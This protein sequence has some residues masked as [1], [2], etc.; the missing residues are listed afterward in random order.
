MLVC[1]GMP[2][3]VPDGVGGCLVCNGVNTYQDV[4]GALSCK[5]V[6]S[7]LSSQFVVLQPT[8]TSDRVCRNLTQCPPGFFHIVLATATSDRLCMPCGA[9]TADTDRNASTPCDD[10]TAGTYAAFAGIDGPCYVCPAGTF[11]VSRRLTSAGCSGNC[12]RGTY[13]PPGSTSC[14]LCAPGTVD[15]D[16][17]SATPCVVCN[18]GGYVTFGV[19]GNCSAW[20]CP[21]GSIDA[22]SNASTPCV[23]CGAGTYVPAGQSGACS[24][25]ACAAGTTDQDSNAS[26]ACTAC[27]PGTFVLPGQTG[28]CSSFLCPTGRADTDSNP[29][30]LCAACAV[31][32]YQNQ[33]GATVCLDCNSSSIA[34]SCSCSAGQFLSGAC[35]DL[36]VCSF[37]QFERI[38]P[39]ATSDRVCSNVTQCVPGYSNGRRRGSHR[40]VGPR[41][42]TM[43][44]GD[45]GY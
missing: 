16:S 31:G 27:N 15:L 32:T 44:G 17:N 5:A 42:H 43:R 1:A 26:T 7:C 3:V 13:S 6:T 41:V 45:H 34:P 2:G 38:M 37:G 30:T 36:T 14:P 40:D 23:S 10:C 24:A 21:A 25:F 33:R 8:A 29:S 20:L 9:G 12:P 22:D 18:A 28:A 39:T 35:I 4:A 11:G 19:Y